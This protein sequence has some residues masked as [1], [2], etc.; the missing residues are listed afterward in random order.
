MAAGE[1]STEVTVQEMLQRMEAG[2]QRLDE[3]LAGLSEGQMT[4][5]GREG[6]AV[7]DHLAHLAAWAQGIAALLR[8]E[9]RWA[10][11]GL[12]E[13]TMGDEE[14]INEALHQQ[15]RALTLAEARTTFDAA[16]EGLHAAVAALDDADLLRPYSDF[17]GEPSG[18]DVRPIVGWIVGNSFGHYDE[19]L[20][21]IEALVDRP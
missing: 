2:R 15:G 5:V 6:W 8:G 7:K 21:W 10:A 19:H 16:H 4:R 11:M 1:P 3:A 13:A 14:A 18:D 17:L 20:P 9:P 12:D